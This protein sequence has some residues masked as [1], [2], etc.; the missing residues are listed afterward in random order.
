[1]M[2]SNSQKRNNSKLINKSK[3]RN[4]SQERIQQR[5]NG[6]NKIVNFIG[7]YIKQTGE[8]EIDQ[9]YDETLNNLKD[10]L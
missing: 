9:D 10:F 1:M 7:K 6:K 5:K 2:N 8:I 3:E 4:L